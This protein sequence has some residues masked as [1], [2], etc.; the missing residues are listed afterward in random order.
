MKVKMISI[1]AGPRGTWM[2]GCTIDLPDKEAKGL[3]DGGYAENV[4]TVAP[5]PAREVDVET[6]TVKVP[7]KAV[8]RGK[9]KTGRRG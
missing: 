6:A 2:A 5:S 7:E 3:V 9:G 4:A 8:T 1:Y